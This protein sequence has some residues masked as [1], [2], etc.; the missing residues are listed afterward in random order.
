MALV[1]YFT[2]E[3]LNNKDEI[4]VIEDPT[5]FNNA[6]SRHKSLTIAVGFKS[7]SLKFKTVETNTN[8]S[9]NKKNKNYYP[10]YKKTVKNH[11]A[12]S[13]NNRIL[14]N[15]NNF[16][17]F[18]SEN[19]GKNSANNMASEIS[20]LPSNLESFNSL[21]LRTSPKSFEDIATNELLQTSSLSNIN[22]FANSAIQRSGIDPGDDPDPT[23]NPIPVGDGWS[24]LIALISIYSVWKFSTLRSV[25]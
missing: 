10:A 1:S 25:K 17:V 21:N 20:N 14:S 2:A 15:E 24:F 8:L 18:S 5:Y 23:E 3:E 9:E 4:K 7:T 12:K 22:L 13:T 19:N 16:D 6:A 11:Q